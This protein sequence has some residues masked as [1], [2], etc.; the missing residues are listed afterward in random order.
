MIDAYRSVHAAGDLTVRMQIPLSVPTAA[1][2]NR[3]ISDVLYHWASILRDRGSRDDMLRLDGICADAGDATVA[4]TISKD[5]P[6]EQ[7]AG[8][9]YQSLPHD[10]FVELGIL[11]AQL[12]LRLNCLVCYDLERVLRAYE[13]I[14]ARIDI[15]WRRW[16]IIHV[17]SATDDQ[18]RR[19]KALGLIATVTPGFMFMASDRFR[20]STSCGRTA[21]PFA[22]SWTPACR[23]LCRPTT[24]RLRC[25]SRCGRPCRVG[26]GIWSAPLGPDRLR[27]V[28]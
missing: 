22:A 15:T 28:I 8:H 11:A 5:Y 10:R 3:K 23:W 17:I 14:N 6:Y 7:W 4:H 25:C 2:D 21:S 1:F 18:I 16:V 12:G 19:I 20:A 24:S 26:T 13:A 27:L 9:F